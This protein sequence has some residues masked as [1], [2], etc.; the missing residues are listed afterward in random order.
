MVTLTQNFKLTVVHRYC[1]S[2]SPVPVIVVRP[3]RKVRKSM[4][5]RRADGRRRHQ[6]DE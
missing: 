1:V 4:E 5:K 6:F 2:H 3:E